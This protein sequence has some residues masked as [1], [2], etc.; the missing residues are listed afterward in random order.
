MQPLATVLLHGICL[1]LRVFIFIEPLR[2]GH[3]RRVLVAQVVRLKV[4][5]TGKET[6]SSKTFDQCDRA[7]SFAF[8]EP[9]SRDFALRGH[10]FPEL[11]GILEVRRPHLFVAAEKAALGRELFIRRAG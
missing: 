8:A 10:L 11:T 4:K 2:G 7:Q 6:G 3:R 9:Y 5:F 1:E